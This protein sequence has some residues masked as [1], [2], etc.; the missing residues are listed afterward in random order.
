LAF[1]FSPSLF[2]GT[3]YLQDETL[4]QATIDGRTETLDEL[5]GTTYSQV[6][7]D[8]YNLLLQDGLTGV[9][10]VGSQ[11][12]VTDDFS[13]LPVASIQLDATDTSGNSMNWINMGVD[14]IYDGTSSFTSVSSSTNPAVAGQPVTL[15]A[16]VTGDG[17]TPTGTV[18]F[19][20]GA[21][22]LGTGTLDANGNATFTTSSL[23]LGSHD[24]T[25]VYG[26]DSN[27]LGS[28]GMLAQVVSQENN[29]FLSLSSSAPSNATLNQPV[30][31][32]ATI[33]GGSGTPTG[34]VTFMADNNVLGTGTLD[35]SG[36]ATFTT[37][38]L[39]LGSHTITAIYGGDA[40][41]GSNSATLNQIINQGGTSTSL[42]ASPNP[43]QP[44]QSVTFTATLTY[45]NAAGTPTGVVTFLDGSTVLGTGTLTQ[46]G[47][48]MQATF[49][50][51]PLSTGSHAITAV[52]GG[53]NIFAA[54]SS[55]TI[56]TVGQASG[57]G[58]AISVASSA[59]PALLGQPVTLTATVS[60]LSGMPTGTVTF[61]DGT[62]VLGT[63]P[64][65]LVGGQAQATLTTSTLGLGEHDII[66][67][68]SGDGTYAGSANAIMLPVNQGGTSTSLS[69]S[70]NPSPLG[71]SVTFTATVQ[72]T[73]MGAGT[74][75][76]GVTFYDGTIPLGTSML[77]LVNGQMQATFTTAALGLG[78]HRIIAVYNG[79]ST[80]ADSGASLQQTIS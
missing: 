71:Q 51:S 5:G 14:A 72:A 52:Y 40:T 11:V 47:S 73:G 38:T 15:T 16:T 55:S 35:A 70:A 54:S 76:G 20:D 48:Q 39:S 30:T 68:Y 31:F 69:S 4:I 62:T 28:S 21:N 32:T 57:A 1:T 13:G 46:V 60:G 9:S 42:S 10:L 12:I 3:S 59:N 29:S 18:T 53:D 33:N 24:I 49:T 22:V 78:S 44:G 80:F 74:P 43:A 26:G 77:T 75:T 66:A 37:S 67:V 61:M 34:T 2:D 58:S 65:A 79:D 36:K 41:Y 27:Y 19:Q 8:L 25:A 50:T 63:A 7:S 56:E 45:N 23:T 17:V 6:A 64:L